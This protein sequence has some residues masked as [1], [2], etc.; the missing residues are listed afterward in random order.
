[1]QAQSIDELQDELDREVGDLIQIMVETKPVQVKKSVLDE[2]LRARVM[3]IGG[4][5]IK[6]GQAE[7]FQERLI[8]WID[9]LSVKIQTLPDIEEAIRDKSK[10]MTAVVDTVM[11][12]KSRLKKQRKKVS[13]IKRFLEV[14]AEENVLGPCEDEGD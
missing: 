9:V 12:T 8:Q 7:E 11:E 13:K 4:V 6:R 1:M 10:D 5:A 2:L 14:V 3:E